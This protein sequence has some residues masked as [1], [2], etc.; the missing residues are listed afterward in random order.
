MPVD[1]REP[2][3]V[4]VQLIYLLRHG[5]TVWNREDRIQGRRDAPLTE[6][7]IEQARRMGRTLQPLLEDEAP[8]TLLASPLGRARR[9]A[10]L[11]LEAIRPFIAEVRTDA[12]LMEMSWGAWEGLVRAE[13]EARDAERWCRFEADPWRVAPPGGE[14]Y[15]E[16]AQRARGWLESVA[17]ERRLIVVAHGGFGRVL[18]AHYA[19]L[20]PAAALA[21]KAPQDALHRLEAGTVAEIPTDDVPPP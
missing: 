19:G 20:P 10:E 13:I 4:T 8:F 9:S 14:S 17:D 5:E 16:L 18:R 15:G 6:R 11:I 3:R 2:E 1:G 7:G 21:L 12:R